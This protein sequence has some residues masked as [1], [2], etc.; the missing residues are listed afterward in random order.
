MRNRERFARDRPCVGFSG[1]LRVT[2]L[3]D[4]A[5]CAELGK[6]FAG[7]TLRGERGEVRDRHRAIDDHPWIATLFACARM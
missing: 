7:E 1:T 6:R 3:F 2:D 5:L 4:V